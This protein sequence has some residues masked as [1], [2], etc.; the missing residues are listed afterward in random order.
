M[1]KRV[2]IGFVGTQLDYAGKGAAR[3]EKWRPT[4]GLCQQEDLLI[5]RL[6]LIHDARSRG[7][8]ER[9][10]ND[11]A[12]VSPE[13]VVKGVEITLRD[14][15]DFEEVYTTLHDFARAYPFDLDAEDYLI[16][17]TTGTHVAQ[18]CWFLL[19]EA[20]YPECF[21]NPQPDANVM[22]FWP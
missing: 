16:H 2:A 1:K 5:H 19:A 6:E 8:F 4:V 13:T 20:R 10:R 12:S 9:L 11:I 15:W 18:I 14:P 17:I 21:I 3:W 22:I 7:L